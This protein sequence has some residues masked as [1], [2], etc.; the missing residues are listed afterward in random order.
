[1]ITY[2]QHLALLNTAETLEDAIEKLKGLI[3]EQYKPTVSLY[4]ISGNAN[5]TAEISGNKG[6]WELTQL[7]HK[8]QQLQVSIVYD[9]YR[10][11]EFAMN[12]LFQ[13]DDSVK[14]EWE[15]FIKEVLNFVEL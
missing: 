2:E 13:G 5:F 7:R 15:Y 14:K 8:N 3:E 1:M 4:I 10:Q 6:V 12:S 11:D 9:I